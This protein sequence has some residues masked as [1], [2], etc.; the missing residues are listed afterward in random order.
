MGDG[1]Y[2]SWSHSCRSHSGGVE[3]CNGYPEAFDHMEQRKSMLARAK[4]L[5]EK[6]ERDK[7]E[8]DEQREGERK[9]KKL[10]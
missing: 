7:I 8:T 3:D 6:V 2:D 5:E 4:E 9:G 10:L 1:T